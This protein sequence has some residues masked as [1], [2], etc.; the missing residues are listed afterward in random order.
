MREAEAIGIQVGLAGR[1]M[2]P[3]AHDV[4]GQEQP[5]EFLAHQTRILT[6][7]RLSTQTQMGFL[8]ID[9]GFDLPALMIAVDELEGWSEARGSSKVVTK[10]CS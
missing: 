6:A 7:Q 4:M 9:A 3:P 5:V 1:L 10:R 2:H 8:L